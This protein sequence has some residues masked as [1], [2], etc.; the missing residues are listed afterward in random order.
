AQWKPAGANQEEESK[1]EGRKEE[2]RKEEGRKEMNH[3]ETV[4]DIAAAAEG[5]RGEV[6]MTV[7]TGPVSDESVRQFDQTADF[8]SS[9]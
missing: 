9:G 5:D 2:G 6:E 1:E 7:G 3:Q 8:V 4:E